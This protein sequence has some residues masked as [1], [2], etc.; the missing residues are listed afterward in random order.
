MKDY[1]GENRKDAGAGGFTILI[2]RLKIE[3]SWGLL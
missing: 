2:R 3:K 1:G